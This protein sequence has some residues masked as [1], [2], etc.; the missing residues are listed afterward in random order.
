MDGLD[1]RNS[2]AHFLTRIRLVTLRHGESSAQLLVVSEREALHVVDE[3]LNQLYGSIDGSVEW[4]VALEAV[5]RETKAERLTL[6]YVGRDGAFRQESEP[7]DPDGVVWFQRDYADKDLRIARVLQGRRGVMT[8]R[9]LM[10]A[11]EIA[12]C[13][14]HN[15]YYRV[16]PECWHT[17]MATVDGEKALVTPI[18]HRGAIRG[19]FS[20]EEGRKL[21]LLSRHLARVVEIREML[22][23]PTLSNDGIV[24]AYDALDDGIVIFDQA[25]VVLHMNALARRL[26]AVRDGIELQRGTLKATDAASADA[27]LRMMAATIRVAAGEAHELPKPVGIR[28]QTTPHPLIVRSYVAPSCNSARR[29]G[30]L[31][32]QERT[33]WSR[34]EVETIRTATGLTPAEARLALALLKGETVVSYARRHDLSEHTVRTHIKH[35]HEKLG[36][37]R[38]VEVVALLARLFSG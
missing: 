22:P 34:P 13:P 17:M 27:L 10:S 21:Q 3:V 14:I 33:A 38:Q 32:L 6:A 15:E 26:A 28:R 18:I 30:V 9:H 4:R 7:F 36:V 29:I 8:T 37:S 19:E 1:G 11:E 25:G 24:A 16:Y 12:R 23:G 31:K 20:P 5:M 35:I 2:A